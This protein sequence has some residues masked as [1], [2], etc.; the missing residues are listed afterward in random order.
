MQA[1]KSGLWFETPLELHSSQTLHLFFAGQPLFETPLEL[2]S[3]Q[4][5]HLRLH[6]RAWFET[7][8]EL[9]S[10]QTRQRSA[11]QALLV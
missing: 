3:S 9:H 1:D 7:P 8:L 10:S 4:T 5:K 2:H 11:L 6:P